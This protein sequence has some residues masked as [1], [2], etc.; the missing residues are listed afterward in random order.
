MKMDAGKNPGYL[1]LRACSFSFDFNVFQLLAHFP[2]QFDNIDG[3]TGSLA[4]HKVFCR[5]W[6]L[7]FASC[8]PPS[9][10]N[11]GMSTLVFGLKT[12]CLVDPAKCYLHV[13]LPL[14]CL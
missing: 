7:V 13:I 11:D 6:S 12:H 4:Y 9:L 5:R 2:Q 10:N 3:S 1:V 14:K 8:T